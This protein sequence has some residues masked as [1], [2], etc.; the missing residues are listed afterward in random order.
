MVKISFSAVSQ[1][2]VQIL[3][4]PL[5]SRVISGAFPFL[6][7]T[8]F[9]YHL[10][11]EATAEA[12]PGLLVCSQGGCEDVIVPGQGSSCLAHVIISNY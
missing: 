3:L 8:L 12:F 2:W 1:F 5:T 7:F 4:P 9:S 10:R 11:I 6:V